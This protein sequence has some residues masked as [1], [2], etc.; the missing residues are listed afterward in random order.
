MSP[1]FGRLTVAGVGLIGGSLA[2]AAREA[3]L[4]GEV[5]G[6]GRSEANLARGAR[7][8]HRRPRRD[9]TP[10]AAAAGADLVVLAAPVR[11]VRRAGRRASGRT[12]RP[13]TMLTDVG[14]VKGGAGRRAGGALARSGPRSSARHPIAGSEAAGRRRGACRPVSR[15]A[16]HPDADAA[17]ATRGARAR[18]RRSGRASGARVEEMDAAAHDAILARVSHLPHL[19]AYALVDALARRARRRRARS[20]DVR[21][22]RAARHDAHRRQPRRAVARHRARQRRRR[23][24]RRSAS[25]APR[26]TASS[27]LDRRGRRAPASSAALD[28]RAGARGAARRG[29][30]MSARCASRMPARPLRGDVAVPG[31]KSIGHRALLL[32]ALADGTTR[33]ARASRAAPTCAPR[34]RRCAALGATRRW[35]RATR[36]RVIGRRA[37]AGRGSRRRRSTAPTPAPRCA[38]AWALVAGRRRAL[39]ARRRRARCAAAR[40]SASRSRCAP[41]AR[42]SRRPAAAPPVVVRRRRRSTAIDWTLPVASAQVKSAILLAGLAR[43]RHDARARAA[44][45]PRPHRAPA[46]RTWACAVARADGS[47]DASRAA[48]G[49]GRPTSRCPGDPSS[50]AFLVVAA[51]LVPGS[52]VRVRDVGLNPTR[53]GALAILRRMGADIRVER[54][55]RRGRASRAA[56]WSCARRACAAR[57]SRPTRCRRRS[58]SC[59]SW[60][61][62]RRSPTARRASRGAAELRVKESDRLAAL[63][64]LG[65]LGV[66]VDG[67]RRRPRRA[68]AR[69]RTAAAA[70]RDRRRTAT[71]ASPW[72]SRSP[73]CEPTAASRSPTRSASACRF[74]AS[75]RASP[76]LGAPVEGGVMRRLVVAI[77]GP[78]GAGKSTASRGARRAPRLRATSTPARCIARS[79]CSRTSAASRSTTTRRWRRLVDGLRFEQRDG[80]AGS[81]VDGRDLS[82]AIRTRRRRRA[83]VEGLD[84]AGGARAAGG[85]AARLGAARRRG[86]GGAR[87]R[88]GRV[89]GRRRSRST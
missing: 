79:A 26:S 70:G 24:A 7:A 10:A 50:A 1:L 33:G 57:R 32:G 48:S 72:R 3:G 81:S 83:G 82:Q 87:H 47:V 46:R 78:A 13:G 36:S 31:D 15:P 76:A 56:I 34:S 14:S 80:G 74:R 75:S 59:R 11:R 60:R 62:P 66:A 88:H 18:A 37:R 6:F 39:H 30:A 54:A 8:R 4:V 44:A 17:H 51:L 25:S 16:L 41:W 21:R 29:R 77:D 64:Q 19:V 71:T 38:S 63:E 2:L 73:G 52:A 43:A 68:R 12:S 27:A 45:E 61:L 85:A 42:A 89:P 22:Q 28:A 67:R 55:A 84:A 5:V 53:T 23:C 35:T 69:R 65:A 20:L 40:W 9:A 49:S 86:D 58:T